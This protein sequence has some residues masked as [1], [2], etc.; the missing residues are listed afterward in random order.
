MKRVCGLLFA[1]LF[2][3]SLSVIPALAADSSKEVEQLKSEVQKLLK[4][5][6]DLEKKQA[7]TTTKVAETEKKVIDV[8]KVTD[9]GEKKLPKVDLSA[10]IRAFYL[11]RD[12]DKE[13]DYRNNYFEIYKFRLGAKGEYGK[14]IQFYGML[15]ANESENYSVNLWEAAVQFTLL[16][17]LV[18][19]IGQTRVPFS[20]HNFTARHQSPVMSS[21]GNYFLPTQFK[22]ALRAVNPYVGG[23]R[24]SDPFKRNDYEAVVKG[25]IKEG[26]FKYYV[27]IA[28]ED[29]SK[30]NKVWSLT[31]GFGD[32]TIATGESVKDKRSLEYDARIEFTP[33]MFGFKSEG[34][35]SDP[36]LRVK[37]TYL[38][39]MDTMTFG[40]GYHHEKHLNGAD[41]SKYGES[42][43]SRDAWA[44][45]F[46]FEK[47]F[48]KYI[49]GL[50]LGYMNFANTHFYQTDDGYEKGD[51][52]TTYA[53]AHL[54]YG[55]KIW[56][57]FPGIG[58]RYEH[59]NIDGEYKNTEGVT[60]K[61][62]VYQRYGACLSYWF[63]DATR[64]GIGAD[65]VKADDALKA[66]FKTKKWEDSTL[67]WYL[68][69]YA[70]F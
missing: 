60:K 45:D 6:E 25:S 58:F 66:Y 7:E 42:S 28:N 67:V 63:N 40:I 44:A 49:T 32:A 33:T 26:M 65:Y 57:G 38:G 56:M 30:S 8:E 39:K 34:T 54:I 61:D 64:V 3:F 1:F 27:G 48:G 69:V 29:R 50:E 2:L 36:S 14:L 62:L 41:Q 55:E 5:I 13:H 4:R 18:L 37:Q 43:L 17:E 70:Q 21:D 12:E 68:G 19:E 46:S 16:P 59:I 15:D 20:R 47:L 24:S 52:W 51:A 11:N 31:G 9:K 10:Q 35:V 22:D 23:Y 53:D